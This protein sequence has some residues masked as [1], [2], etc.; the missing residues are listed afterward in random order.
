MYPSVVEVEDDHLHDGGDK[1]T[2]DRSIEALRGPVVGVVF[3]LQSPN[4][5]AQ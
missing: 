5:S 1:E 3:N 2:Y 4:S